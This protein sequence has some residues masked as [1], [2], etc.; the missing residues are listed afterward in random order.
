[1]T[2]FSSPMLPVHTPAIPADSLVVLADDNPMAYAVAYL[3]RTVPAISIQNN[4]MTPE[5]CTRLQAI[6]EQRVR[7]HAGPIFLLRKVSGSPMPEAVLAYGLAAE[8]TCL[9]M[10]TSLD[11]LELCPLVRRMPTPTVCAATPAGP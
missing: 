11:A 1:M 2:R 8:G 3:P 6:A 7:Q 9:P 10:P 5:R 4:F